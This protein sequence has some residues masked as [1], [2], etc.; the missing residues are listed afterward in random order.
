MTQSA[1]LLNPSS[2]CCL[3]DS[4]TALTDDDDRSV[5]EHTPLVAGCLL[6]RQLSVYPQDLYILTDPDFS[7]VTEECEAAILQGIYPQRIKK[8]SSG[9]Y[10]VV[11]RALVGCF[12]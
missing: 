9:S 2:S 6:E 7:V 5:T 1:G 8:G 12:Y 11:S 3:P 10:F 4:S